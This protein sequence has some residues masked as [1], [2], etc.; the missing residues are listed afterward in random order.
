MSEDKYIM[1]LP[2]QSQCSEINWAG[3]SVQHEI[4]C[5][6]FADIC[7]NQWMKFNLAMD[8]MRET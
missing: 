1:K 8:D 2:Y 5:H 6:L 4:G 3:L 7:I